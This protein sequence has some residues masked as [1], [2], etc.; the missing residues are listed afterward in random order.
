MET[1]ILE[2][3]VDGPGFMPSRS[4]GN[5]AAKTTCGANSDSEGHSDG[6]PVL[7]MT[8][9]DPLSMS[10]DQLSNE[11]AIQN[12]LEQT[13]PPFEHAAKR[14]KYSRLAATVT[15]TFVALVISIGIALLVAEEAD[16]ETSLEDMMQPLDS[17]AQRNVAQ[18]RR[19]EDAASES[20]VPLVCHTAQEGEPCHAAVT[21]AMQDGVLSNPEWYEPLEADSTFEAFQALLHD[22]RHEANCSRPCKPGSTSQAFKLP[23]RAQLQPR[24]SGEWIARRRRWKDMNSCR[25]RHPWDGSFDLPRGWRCTGKVVEPAPELPPP[26]GVPN[27]P[28]INHYNG[29]NP[30]GIVADARRSQN[31]FV[32]LGDWGRHDAPGPCQMAVADKL[33]AYVAKQKELEKTLLAVGLVGDNFY[34]TGATPEAWDRQWEPAYETRN[35]N[36]ILH[37]I[38]WIATLGNH[39]YGDNDPYAFCPHHNP[40]GTIDGQAY[41]SHQLNRDRN[42]TRPEGTEH[43]WFPDYNFHYEIPEASLEFISLDTNY[44]NVVCNLGPDSNGFR[45]AFGK[46]YGRPH[47]EAFMRGVSEAGKELLRERARNGTANTTVILQHYPGACQKDIFEAAL[48]GR[49]TKVL[50]AYGHVHDQKCE[51]NDSSGN[52]NMVLTG[53]GGGCCGNHRAGFTAVHLTDDGGFVTDLRSPDVSLPADNCHMYRRI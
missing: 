11:D 45:E 15:V 12:S 44:N 6:S 43:Y 25:R 33:K 14:L 49:Q 48:A 4:T 42:P 47:V 5:K 38:P 28:Y 13:G 34:W 27:A 20:G 10:S 2:A 19:L 30:L 26:A 23:S 50:C 8:D 32:L 41:S 53:G 37:K 18:Q 1:L 31:Y 22:G 39:D 29:S 40:R 52:C 24:V 16:R 35:P 46:C 17:E 3:G 9:S 36:S 21:W 51:G 7:I